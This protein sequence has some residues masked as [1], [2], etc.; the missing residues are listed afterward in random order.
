MGH[1]RLAGAGVD[2]P[3]RPRHGGDGLHRGADPQHLTGAH[4]TLG[5]AGTARH[6]SDP[7]NLAVGRHD[8][9]VRQAAAGPGQLEAVADLDPL[10]RLDAH[11]RPGELGIEPPVAHHV[12]AEARRHAPGDHLDHAAQRVAGLLAVL[13]L[14]QHQRGRVSGSKQR[15]GSS[16]IVG[17]SAYVGSRPAGVRIGPS[18]TTWLRISTPIR[19]PQERGRHRRDRHPGGGL[20]RAGPFEDRPGLVEVV[21]LHAR[22]GRHARA[23]AGSAGRC[24]PARPEPPPDTGSADITVSHLGH[25]VLPIWIAIGPPW[26][27]SVPDPAEDRHGVGLELHPR[28]ATESEPAPSER[29]GDVVGRDPDMSRHPFEGGDERGPVGLTSGQPSEHGGQSVTRGEAG[30]SP[31]AGQRAPTSSHRIA[32]MRAQQAQTTLVFAPHRPDARPAGPNHP[33]FAPHRPD[34]SRTGPIHPRAQALTR[35][36]SPSASRPA[37]SMI[38]G[39]GDGRSS[40][41]IGA[42]PGGRA[43]R[44]R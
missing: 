6:A 9:V 20:P 40:A 39:R 12:R 19:L 31:S 13:H 2:G 37:A 18:S 7:A 11:Q 42:P 10:D 3:Q 14:G 38:S 8:L 21:L 43:G 35:R 27:S 22:P 33:V 28:A 24:G 16:S 25:S 34:A 23:A 36:S 4:P 41:R 29:R 15:S 1:S 44:A 32:Q 5:P 26:V 30:A 17:R